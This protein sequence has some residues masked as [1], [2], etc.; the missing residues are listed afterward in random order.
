MPSRSP[1]S[2]RQQHAQCISLRG[3]TYARLSAEAE[4]L[5]LSG[6]SALA[7]QWLEESPAMQASAEPRPTTEPDETPSGYIEF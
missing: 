7:Q 2:K 5:G 1:R 4:R 6:P 3:E